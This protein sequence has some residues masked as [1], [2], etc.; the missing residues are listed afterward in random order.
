MPSPLNQRIWSGLVLGPLV[1]IAVWIGTPAFQLMVVAAMAVLAWEWSR[2]FDAP[3]PQ[4]P[5]V[6]LI[7]G[8]VAAVGLAAVYGARVGIAVLIAATVLMLA[9]ARRPWLAMGSVYLGLPGLLL[10]A[11]RADSECG[12]L[13]VFWLLAIVWASDIGA[14]LVGSTVGGPKLAPSISPNKTWAGF[15]GGLAAAALAGTA[16]ASFAASGLTAARLAL[17][18][19]GVG[20]ATQAGDLAESWMKR[21]FGVKDTS[22]LIPGHGGLLDRV[23]GLL[24]ATLVTALIV[25]WLDG[26]ICTWH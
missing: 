8:L 21:R 18:G 4:P 6:V 24:A 20:L 1:L 3:P 23:D 9:V 5:G 25:A 10:I 13:T 19:A 17:I 11:L 7:G 2:L 14:F 15:A 26:S 16:V 12:R 22:G